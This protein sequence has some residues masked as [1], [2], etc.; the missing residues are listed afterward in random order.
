MPEESKAV[1]NHLAN[2]ASIT[3]LGAFLHNTK[4]DDFHRQ[5][6]Y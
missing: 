3:Q 4:I 1:V 5:L 6:M 2:N